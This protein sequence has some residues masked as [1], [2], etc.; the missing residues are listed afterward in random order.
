MARPP[1]GCARVRLRLGG[2]A[3]AR[4]RSRAEVKV[5]TEGGFHEAGVTPRTGG[6][7]EGS[8]SPARSSS[9]TSRSRWRSPSIASTPV[10]RLHKRGAGD[11]T[12]RHPSGAR[13]KVKV[14]T[15]TAA[16]QFSSWICCRTMG[17]G[18]M[19]GLPQEVVDELGAP[20][21]RRRTQLYQQRLAAHAEEAGGRSAS[22][23]HASRPSPAMSL[24]CRETA[25]VVPERSDG[26]HP[27]F[28]SSRSNGTWRTPRRP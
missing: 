7:G 11:P 13:R 6:G 16:E 15:I 1:G 24:R 3:K 2:G 28:R 22:R 12:A 9:S 18:L 5:F 14:N 8:R 19:P 4:I 26:S 21:A 17:R 20:R 10:P 23:S 25:N 27:Q